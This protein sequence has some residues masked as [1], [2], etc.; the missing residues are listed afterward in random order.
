MMSMYTIIEENGK[1]VCEGRLQD[2]TERWTKDTLDEAVESL[3]RFA[4]VM[5]HDKNLKR[6]HITFL[7][8]IQALQTQYVEHEIPKKVK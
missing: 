5:N 7:K 8:P 6:K 1:F 2:G 3:K 4:D